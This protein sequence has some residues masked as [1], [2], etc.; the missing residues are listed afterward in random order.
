VTIGIPL[1]FRLRVRNETDTADLLVASTIPG[2]NP[3]L[4]TPPDTGDG[5]QVDPIT[6]QYTIG[7]YEV[8]VLDALVGAQPVLVA[9]EVWDYDPAGMAAA[10]PESFF[11][12]TGTLDPSRTS[13]FLNVRPGYTPN[14]STPFPPDA[15]TGLAASTSLLFASPG[16]QKAY[17]QHTF[18]GLTPGATYTVLVPISGDNPGIGVS[19]NGTL[20]QYGAPAAVVV[21]IPPWQQLAVTTTADGS[22]NIVV[23]LGSWPRN[24]I[25]WGSSVFRFGDVKIFEGTLITPTYLVTSVLN[26]ANGRPQL[27]SK[28]AFIDT[29]PDLGSTWNSYVSGYVNQLRLTNA[30]R[31]RFTVGD[32]QRTATSKMLWS[33]CIDPAGN[34][35]KGSCILGGP[36]RDGFG[37]LPDAGQWRFKVLAVDPTWGV[38]LQVQLA[39]AAKN[40]NGPYEPGYSV[41]SP[42]AA[43]LNKVANDFL[44]N[45]GTT[46][47]FT[48]GGISYALNG[49][50]DMGVRVT[51][52]ATGT[53]EGVFV[54][55]VLD[56]LASIG[57]G[58]GVLLAL[59][60]GLTMAIAW[61][62]AGVDVN[63]NPQP[64]QPSVG[65]LLDVYA[66]PLA[67]SARSPLHW[68]GHV[69]D[70]VTQALTFAGFTFDATS[71]TAVKTILGPTLFVLLRIT[72][73]MSL[74]DLLTLIFGLFRFSAR[75][76]LDGEYVF[77]TT[78]PAQASIVGSPL[79]VN[80]LRN[81][82]GDV[83]S[84]QEA[85]IITSFRLDEQTFT[86]WTGQDGSDRPIDYLAS[87]DRTLI[88]DNPQ[89]PPSLID[90]Q[91]QSWTLPG[92]II[93]PLGLV[94]NTIASAV[95]LDEAYFAALAFAQFNR[96]GTGALE[97]HAELLGTSGPG[98][99]VG[100]IVTL[101]LPQRPVGNVRGGQRLAQ[102]LK[103]TET[104]SGPVF[105]GWDVS[106]TTITPVVPTFT[107]AASSSDP[108][109]VATITLTNGAALLAVDAQAR[110][111]WAAG[112]SPPTVG[113]LLTYL[114]VPPADLTVINTPPVQ[115]GTT[116]W[117]RM[118]AEAPGELPSAYTAWQSV[119]LT[120]GLGVPTG[121]TSTPIDGANEAISWTPVGSYDFLI[122]FLKKSSDTQFQIVQFLPEGS[123]SFILTNLTAGVAYTWGVEEFDVGPVPFP[124]GMA[125]ASFTAGAVV[126]TLAPPTLPQAFVGRRDPTTGQTIIDGTFGLN[127]L[128]AMIPETIQFE[129]AVE[130]AVGSGTPGPYSVL[131]TPL[132]AQQGFTTATGQAPN[133]GLHRYLR[134]KATW[135]GYND[136]T[137]TA[138]QSVLP[139]V[140]TAQDS[141]GVD[142]TVIVSAA[143]PAFPNASV[144]TDSPNIHFDFSVAGIVKAIIQIASQ[145]AGDLMTFAGGVWTRLGIGSAN[146]VLTVVGGAPAWAP[147]LGIGQPFNVVLEFGDEQTAPTVNGV[148][149]KFAIGFDADVTEWTIVGGPSGTPGSAVVDVQTSAFGP[150]LSFATICGTDQPT[151]SAAETNQDSTL[152]GWSPHIT[153]GTVLQGVL[154]SLATFK[155][156]TVTLKCVRS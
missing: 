85:T 82:A 21:T 23:Q 43:L 133:D 128:A 52:V 96:L 118:R 109:H 41:G 16:Y 76:G 146:Q 24:A 88:V 114:L 5:Q 64:P 50:F 138:V 60:Q 140:A 107:L 31:W 154:L 95:G 51:D 123:N 99:K 53:L 55:Y 61:T 127:V 3:Y 149:G 100:D 58:G 75:V 33:R 14:L 122:V 124:G 113:S 79:G 22:G 135:P 46:A 78:D 137:Y 152:T 9:R 39:N 117:V 36:V 13:D 98:A 15:G 29:T 101:N 67:V 150:T 105:E 84:T 115:Q 103:R 144:A 20:V 126:P 116:L 130:T 136:S 1:G 139:W 49:T 131:A 145:A 11:D 68:F 125:T 81:D 119:T 72:S 132:A 45:T 147:N 4:I 27:L 66:Y 141:G 6:G 93:S 25:E 32:T 59:A 143:N 10:W 65:D 47:T 73:A 121:L 106:A 34:F 83:W 89:S 71:A 30:L 8:D 151:L 134:A 42:T 80:D 92:I 90:G 28:K 104:P 111:E 57:F 148:A 129:V 86:L 2:Q 54:P 48:N 40:A 91:Q 102:V 77:F 112:A 17:I 35:D 19:A 18:S 44:V 62:G 120:G 7:S 70:L 156:V 94:G 37:P 74:T 12:H 97:F 56:D 38:L 69:V 63:G 26:D 142:A 87:R 108:S 153:A 155:K 110:V